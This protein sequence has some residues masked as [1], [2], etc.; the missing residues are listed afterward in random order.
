MRFFAQNGAPAGP[1]AE[2]RLLEISGFIWDWA[3]T[4][5]MSGSGPWLPHQHTGF[6]PLLIVCAAPLLFFCCRS[7]T[8]SIET[9]SDSR[10]WL[11]WVI[12][13]LSLVL[14]VAVMP[15]LFM[16]MSIGL[17]ALGLLLPD[18]LISGLAALY[19]WLGAGVLILGQIYGT[20]GITRR[21]AGGLG[22]RLPERPG[23]KLILFFSGY[24]LMILLLLLLPSISAAAMLL[25][26][27]GGVGLVIEGL[28]MRLRRR[29]PS[30]PKS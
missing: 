29:G 24:A 26:W 12:G 14:L 2:Q 10:L 8:R 11:A 27:I 18:A 17:V 22:L 25:L 3:K 7:V 15:L 21:L 5:I 9:A 1:E 19:F 30:P 23:G 13:L 6:A 28:F 20:Y 4:G 16:M